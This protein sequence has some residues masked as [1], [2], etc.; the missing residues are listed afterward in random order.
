[1]EFLTPIEIL[2]YNNLD[3][4]EA[5]ESVECA[6]V[7]CEITGITARIAKRETR[8]ALIRHRQS[9]NRLAQA[10]QKLNHNL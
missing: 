1:M 4:N 2:T 10:I 6:A 8:L 9:K 5:V 3:L 7:N